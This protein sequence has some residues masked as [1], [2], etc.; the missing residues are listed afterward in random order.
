MA[1]FIC[2][3]L[4]SGVQAFKASF[5][6]KVGL[7]GRKRALPEDVSQGSLRAPRP[8]E[9]E[10]WPVPGNGREEILTDCRPLAAYR[11]LASSEAGRQER[12]SGEGGAG[13]QG[14]TDGC[15]KL[16]CRRRRKVKNR[17][18]AGH[19][20]SPGPSVSPLANVLK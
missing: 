19:R 12:Q 3:G 11:D 5:V 13:S 20:Q 6:F 16:M 4:L 7:N 14:L 1:F 2:K 18:T 17:V 15:H 9:L 8:W 10:T